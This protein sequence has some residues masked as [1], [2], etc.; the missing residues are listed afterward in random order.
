LKELR[1]TRIL[2]DGQRSP[3]GG[4]ALFDV[5]QFEQR[6]SAQDQQPDPNFGTGRRTYL[7]I[8]ERDYFSDLSGVEE[9]LGVED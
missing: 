5:G 4:N 6:H 9:R 8:D 7:I 2:C 1:T 3:K